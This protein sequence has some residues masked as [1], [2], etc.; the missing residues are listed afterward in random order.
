M[1][2]APN[3]AKLAT[4]PT[5]DLDKSAVYE[6][7]DEMNRAFDT[8]TTNYKAHR[9]LRAAIAEAVDRD[10]LPV[11]PVAVRAARKRPVP[12]DK[13]LPTVETLRALVDNLP[14]RYQLT[15]VLCLFMGLRIGEALAVTR[16]QLVNVGTVESPQWLVKVRGNLQRVQDDNGRTTMVWQPPKTKAGSRDVKIFPFFNDVVAAH[17]EN[18]APSDGDGYVTTTREG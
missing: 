14:A 13:E 9:Y 16:N 7:W 3:V 15:G 10:L 17:L 18:F 11:N 6:W 4:L 8:P 2:D 1:A 12:K 5:G